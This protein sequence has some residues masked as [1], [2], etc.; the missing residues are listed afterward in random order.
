MTSPTNIKTQIFHFFNLIHK[1]AHIFGGFE[2]LF[3]SIGWRVIALQ[4]FAKKV[5]HA[6]LE[7]TQF[8]LKWFVRRKFS[9]FSKD[10]SKYNT[11]IPTTS[12]IH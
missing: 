12:K 1:T 7:G 6:D 5:A 4:S 11:H 3:S 8:L 10:L 2:K 9:N